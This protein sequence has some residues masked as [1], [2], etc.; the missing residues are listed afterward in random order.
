MQNLE[1]IH[2][3]INKS[4]KTND[5]FFKKRADFLGFDLIVVRSLNRFY[6]EFI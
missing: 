1:R 3:L 5:W 6:T 4:L 2:E